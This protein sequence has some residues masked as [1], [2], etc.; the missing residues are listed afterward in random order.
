MATAPLEPAW[1]VL[2]TSSSE[3]PAGNCGGIET[4][5]PSANPFAGSI[6]SPDSAETK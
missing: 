1:A 2:L 5:A 4:Y 6:T 3:T